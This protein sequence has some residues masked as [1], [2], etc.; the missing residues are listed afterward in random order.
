MNVDSHSRVCTQHYAGQAH[1]SHTARRVAEHN[2]RGGETAAGGK[3]G[4]RRLKYHH[5]GRVHWPIIPALR[6]LRQQDDRSKPTR[7][8]Q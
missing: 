6:S 1:E 5:H 4:G 2:S 7:A 3:R 8:I